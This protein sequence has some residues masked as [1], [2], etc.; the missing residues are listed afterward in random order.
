MSS[1]SQS[2]VILLKT[3]VGGG[4][5]VCWGGGVGQGGTDKKRGKSGLDEI[6]GRLLSPPRVY[7]EAS[8]KDLLLSCPY[9]LCENHHLTALWSVQPSEQ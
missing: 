9:S 2:N 5:W 7:E 8:Q 3:E 4:V 6:L 1:L